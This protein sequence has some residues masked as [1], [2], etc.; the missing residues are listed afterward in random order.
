LSNG[1]EIWRIQ[2]LGVIEDMN[3][4]R[5]CYVSFGHPKDRHAERGTEARVKE[6]L[7]K[8]GIRSKVN[9]RSFKESI[10]DS[11]FS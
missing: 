6:E 4:T 3:I 10:L 1:F 8:G 5:Y 11:F 9:P 2:F 7:K